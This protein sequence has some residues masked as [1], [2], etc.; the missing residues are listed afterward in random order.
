MH[1]SR[2]AIA[3]LALLPALGCTGYGPSGDEKA[4]QIFV[5]GRPNRAI[6]QLLSPQA[7]ERRWAIVS[8]AREGD[9][10]SVEALTA[11][12]DRKNEPVPLVRATAAVGLRMIGDRRA[13]PALTR[14]A[15]DPDAVVRADVA[16]SLGMLGGADE[17]PVLAAL[18]RPAGEP[19]AA[20]RLQA[21]QALQRLAADAA[22]PELISALQDPDDSVSF[23]AH[24]ALITLTGQNLPPDPRPWRAWLT[25]RPAQ[26]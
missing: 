15:R 3:A 20:V 5:G 22:L 18:L 13:L 14:A 24:Y 23:A 19:D 4:R 17:I 26:P 2:L 7:D 25:A 1:A 9:P 11:L 16:R 8:L 6:E 10:R 21:A 12:L